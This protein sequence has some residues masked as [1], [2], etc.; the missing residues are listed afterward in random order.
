MLQSGEPKDRP[1]WTVDTVF[2][3][4]ADASV[5]MIMLGIGFETVMLTFVGMSLCV[6]ILSAWLA[7]KILEKFLQERLRF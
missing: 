6:M 5:A 2:F 1:G 7:A 3:Y 4:M